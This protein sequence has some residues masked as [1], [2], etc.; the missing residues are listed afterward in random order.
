[1]NIY[2]FI[3]NLNARKQNNLNVNIRIYDIQKNKISKM[4]KI[5][6][7]LRNKTNFYLNS[8]SLVI[9]IKFN[10]LIVLNFRMDSSKISKKYEYSI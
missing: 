4:Q 7:C 3:Q 5:L 9:F 6:L 1:M 2:A 8:F 10:S